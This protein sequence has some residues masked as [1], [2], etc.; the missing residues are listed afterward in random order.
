MLICN[1]LKVGQVYDLPIGVTA[2]KDRPVVPVFSR[3]WIERPELQGDV[4]S[5]G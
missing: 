3:H 1:G 4:V 2:L 5:A